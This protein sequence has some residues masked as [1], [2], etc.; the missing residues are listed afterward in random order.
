M[1]S[2]SKSSRKSNDLLI[3]TTPSGAGGPYSIRYSH[4]G[5][6]F[7]SVTKNRVTVRDGPFLKKSWLRTGLEPTTLRLTEVPSCCHYT[8]LSNTER[9]SY[10]AWS[11][12]HS[13][14]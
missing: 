7:V 12:V 13:T 3:H 5:R 8:P 14:R 10:L 2:S 6:T 9:L 1:I 4:L 11:M